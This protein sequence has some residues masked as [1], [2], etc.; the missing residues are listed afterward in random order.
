[1][2]HNPYQ[3]LFQRKNSAFPGAPIYWSVVRYHD[4]H[5]RTFFKTKL[6]AL[7]FEHSSPVPAQGF[8]HFY[9]DQFNRMFTTTEPE[10][11]LATLL[12]ERAQELR[13]SY[14]YIRLWLS[15]G[16]DSMTA[17]QAFVDNNIYI[18]E[19][20]IH[21]YDND[22]INQIDRFG[23]RALAESAFP[24][25]KQHQDQ[26]KNTKINVYRSDINTLER[27]HLDPDRTGEPA[28][29]HGFDA[30]VLQFRLSTTGAIL[31]YQTPDAA[32]WCDIIGGTKPRLMLKNN[33]WY[34]YVV[35]SSLMSIQ[36]AET[37][38]DFFVSKSVPTLFLKTAY[39]LKNHFEALNLNEEEVKIWS[40]NEKNSKKYNQYIGRILLPDSAYIKPGP[41]GNDEFL[42]DADNQYWTSIRGQVS[43]R[44]NKIFQHNL[45]SFLSTHQYMLNDMPERALIN[46][47]IKSYLSKFYC[48]NDGLMYDSAEI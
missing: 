40:A 43:D 20:V 24:H 4:T 28:H 23:K 18:D 3:E 31:T 8:F 9:E 6:E 16:S 5:Q 15:G 7:A 29:L 17:L 37:T 48:L 22:S 47:S 1:M 13:D 25:L 42:L 33:R 21:L 36:V 2:I 10:K 14:G 26:L 39:L 32:S 41:T 45:N 11:N 27:W 38:E 19:I 30:Q 12:K 34:L 44:V 35:D 46:R